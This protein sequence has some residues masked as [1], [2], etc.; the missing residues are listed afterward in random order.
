MGIFDKLKNMIN[1]KRE[2]IIENQKAR[3]AQEEN[4]YEEDKFKEEQSKP[5]NN[6]IM[7]QK[8]KSLKEF[9]Y[10]TKKQQ[11]WV[12]TGLSYS[13]NLKQQELE[14]KIDFENNLFYHCI[15]NYPLHKQ[16]IEKLEL[17]ANYCAFDKYPIEFI[18]EMCQISDLKY[19]EAC[20][21]LIDKGMSFKD[22]H[23]E[24]GNL[25]PYMTLL[26]MSRQF[27]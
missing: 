22:L 21:Y 19:V 6:Q 24:Q 27:M 10:K 11:N 14:N 9:G 13:L 18:Y 25:L 20:Q 5:N 12:Y 17:V 1:N 3:K 2:E 23:D 16:S 15:T 7:L 4:E 26:K 8:L